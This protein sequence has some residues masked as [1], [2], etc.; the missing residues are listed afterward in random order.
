[1]N[2]NLL[3]QEVIDF[4]KQNENEKVYDVALKKSPFVGVSSK[5]LAQQLF[6][7]QVAKHKFPKLYSLNTIL[8]PP[9]LNL[10]QSSSET[11]SRYKAGLVN[12]NAKVL[13]IT[14]GF[15][16][17][18]IAFAQK[19]SSVTYCEIQTGIFEYAKHNFKALYFAIRPICND[20]I[21]FLKETTDEFDVIFVDPSRRD[22]H[23]RKV[24]RLEECSP[25]LIEHFSLIKS[26]TKRAIVKLSPLVDVDY[27][28]NHIKH[29]SEIHIVA[30]KNEVKELLLV[31]DFS[32]KENDVRFHVVNLE[33]NH[34]KVEFSVEA[35]KLQQDISTPDKYLYEPHS[36]L[37]KSGAFG[38]ISEQFQIKAIAQHTHLFTSTHLIDFPG[39]RF[40]IIKIVKPNKK[41]I[42]K[43]IGTLK[44]NISC[45]NFPLKPEQVKKKFGMIDGGMF[46]VFFTT[47]NENKKIVIICKKI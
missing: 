26:K 3:K 19:T 42:R 4:L 23:L 36:G 10:E 17:D 30:V 35:L 12:K 44:A 2:I 29:L 5:D 15:G 27:C 39:R 34:Q 31:L 1:M 46:Y 7:M 14:G 13:D 8:Y 38:F 11:T 32:A 22:E 47:D 37:M 20:G 45:R 24:F 21:E 6:G 18:C 40:E 16:A 41:E 33:T 28:L 43:T 9:K 25:N